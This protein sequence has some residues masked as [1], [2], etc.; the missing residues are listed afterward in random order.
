[1]DDEVL[2]LLLS[3]VRE[4]FIKLCVLFF[5]WL[6]SGREEFYPS[7]LQR[8]NICSMYKDNTSLLSIGGKHLFDQR[9]YTAVQNLTQY[10]A[11]M[12]P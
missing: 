5:D 11:K 7:S 12:Q 10:V 9:S 1:M 8:E 4:V 6:R 2:D 3:E